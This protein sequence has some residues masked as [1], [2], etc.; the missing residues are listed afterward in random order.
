MHQAAVNLFPA[1]DVELI[2]YHIADFH[3]LPLIGLAGIL[4]L[5][6]AFF[7]VLLDGEENLAWVDRFDEVICNLPADRFFHD[8]LLFVPGNHH[9]GH[10][11]FDVFYFIEHIEP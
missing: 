11:G 2:A 6:L 5:Q 1:F 8:M 10:V 7:E 3:E 4:A 9:H